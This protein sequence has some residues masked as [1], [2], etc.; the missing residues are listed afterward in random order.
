MKKVFAILVLAVSLVFINS[1]ANSPIRYGGCI[2]Y[3]TWLNTPGLNARLQLPLFEGL[4]LVPMIDISVPKFSSGTFINS[5]SLHFH[6]DI[7]I[8]EELDI[9]PL[10][11]AAFKSY[12]DID[13][14]GYDRVFH[15]IVF[16][17]TVG[18][19][20]KLHMTEYFTIFGELRR[21][22]FNY[23]RFVSTIGVLMWAGR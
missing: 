8:I 18:A 10:G 5:V 3:G 12:L 1:S 23:R 6:Y 17:P 19:G 20:A 7:E 14:T 22:M 2:F 16:S 11:G 13:R 21:E 4:S 15:R 9:Y